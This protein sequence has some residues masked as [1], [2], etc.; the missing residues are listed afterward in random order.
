MENNVYPAT[1]TPEEIEKYELS[2][3]RGEI[4]L[5]DD[6]A[7]FYE[8][9]PR[10]LKPGI[11]GFDTE[12]KP[13]F[14]KGRKNNVSLIQLATED[15]ACLIRINKIGI[16]PELAA[17]LSDPGVI[18]AGVAVHDDIKYLR[19]VK[20]FS[21]SGFIDLQKFVKDYGIENSGLKKLTAIILGFRISKRQQVTDWE[22]EKLS[23][24]QL[25]YAA[26]DAWVCQKIYKKLINGNIRPIP[27]FQQR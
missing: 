16:P 8:V 26:T 18:K 22:A 24:A 15:L 12:T 1:I 20:G 10:L 6:L 5:V 21:P 19:K 23:E 25:I 3:F 11:L 13:S 4:V 27:E 14:R 7:G 9:L 17:I 2:W